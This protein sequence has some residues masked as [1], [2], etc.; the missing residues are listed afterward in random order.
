[1]FK[2]MAITLSIAAI[3]LGLSF[4]VNA[5]RRGDVE[6]FN[7][8]MDLVKAAKAG[9]GGVDPER[10]R[11][12]SEAFRAKSEQQL[13][14]STNIIGTWNVHIEESDM[15]GDPFDAL[16]T[17]TSDGTF[18]ETSSLF[19]MGGEG[20]AHGAWERFSRHYRM[21][22]ELFVFDPMTGECAGRVRVR[23]LIMMPDSQHFTSDSVVDF[24]ELDGT[25]IEGIDG[26]PFSGT[27][28][29]PRGI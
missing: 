16:H 29:S 13:L 3:V 8:L 27:R 17:F 20:P 23:N 15:G 9:R 7:G 26:G 5:Q 11:R 19:G 12:V 4:S 28:L 2:K 18:I 24:I 6:R 10:L 1:M 22:F 21:M 25:V 14:G